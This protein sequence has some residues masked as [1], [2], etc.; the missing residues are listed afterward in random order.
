MEAAGILELKV[1]IIDNGNKIIPIGR[2]K[3]GRLSDFLV[4]WNDAKRNQNSI[5]I[6]WEE[7]DI[8]EGYYILEKG[9]SSKESASLVE[10]FSTANRSTGFHEWAG[11]SYPEGQ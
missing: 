5:I 11:N 10:F 7:K 3:E 1:S 6:A 2:D 9:K 4:K 8:F